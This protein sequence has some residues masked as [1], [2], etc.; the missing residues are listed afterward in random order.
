MILDHN[1][2]RPEL[3][4]HKQELV[5]YLRNN[6]QNWGIQLDAVIRQVEESSKIPLT[7]QEKLEEMARKNPDILKLKDRFKLDLGI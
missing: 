7:N 5:S 1:G 2:Q 6:L 4:N 3:D